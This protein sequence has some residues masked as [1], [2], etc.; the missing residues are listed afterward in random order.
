[1]TKEEIRHQCYAYLQEAEIGHEML[2]E[3]HKKLK[4]FFLA[5]DAA[6]SRKAGKDNKFRNALI[7]RLSSAIES[8]EAKFKKDPADMDI[9]NQLVV[10]KSI[11]KFAYEWRE[12]NGP[13]E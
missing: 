7:H 9:R 13:K 3:Q 11:R 2:P 1:M 5:H 10:L 8:G 12:E 4:Q 6:E